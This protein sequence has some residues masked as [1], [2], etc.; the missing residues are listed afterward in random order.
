VGGKRYSEIVSCRNV[1]Q[2]IDMTLQIEIILMRI[3]L[4]NQRNVHFHTYLH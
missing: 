4:V 2:L 3:M 1:S